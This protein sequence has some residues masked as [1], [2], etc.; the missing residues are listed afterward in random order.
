MYILLFFFVNNNNNDLRLSSRRRTNAAES[1]LA[2]T[3]R[4]N[5]F[6]RCG[7][8]PSPFRGGDSAASG[9]LTGKISPGQRTGTSGSSLK[10][11]TKRPRYGDGGANDRS[12]VFIGPVGSPSRACTCVYEITRDPRDKERAVDGAFVCANAYRSFLAR[13]R[14]TARG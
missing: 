4:R 2:N 11:N 5:A 7:A 1:V 10:S 14:Q 13:H 12:D 9:G 8:G 6:R 3:R